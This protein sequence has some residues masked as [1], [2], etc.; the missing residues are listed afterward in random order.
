M[1][2]VVFGFVY[3]FGAGEEWTA[4]RGGGAFLTAGR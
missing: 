4:V 3:D 1:D 2:D